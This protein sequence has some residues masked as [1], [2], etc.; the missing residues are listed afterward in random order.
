MRISPQRVFCLFLCVCFLF[1]CQ[2]QAAT[3]TVNSTLDD[4]TNGCSVGVCTLRE[5]V[6]DAN[7][8]ADSD[9]IVFNL[10]AGQQVITLSSGEISITDWV[11]IVG[12]GA[13]LLKIVGGNLSRVF[14]VTTIATIN[15]LTVSG[16]AFYNG[17]S[18]ELNYVAHGR[19]G[20][21]NLCFAGN[22]QTLLVRAANR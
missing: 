1:I 4:E 11:T 2:A 16:G 15:N 17:G 6:H 19:S 13:N 8:A 12:P 10:P 20:W 5:A 7:S 14:N 18:L 3:F 9:Q 22:Q 21:T